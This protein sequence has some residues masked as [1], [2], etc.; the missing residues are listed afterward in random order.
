[1]YKD[2]AQVLNNLHRISQY[3]FGSDGVA[4]SN[5]DS[6]LGKIL[7]D[8][9]GNPDNN[10]R[11]GRRRVVGTDQFAER[12][13]LADTLYE[14]GVRGIE[15]IRNAF[16][17]AGEKLSKFDAFRLNNLFNKSDN[18]KV[19]YFEAKP[20]RFVPMSEA[21][22]VSV[23]ESFPVEVLQQMVEDGLDVVVRKNNEELVNGID[24]LKLTN[25]FVEHVSDNIKTQ[26]SD[27][28]TTKIS[29]IAGQLSQKFISPEG[30]AQGPEA[31]TTEY[32]VVGNGVEMTANAVENWNSV[33]TN[34][35]TNYT[36][37]TTYNT[38]GTPPVG[39][40]QGAN[41]A[42]QA[43]N[44]VTQITGKVFADGSSGVSKTETALVGELGPEMLV[45]NGRWTT[46]GDNGAEFTQV[47]K[48]DIIF[49][50]KQTEE[51]LSK[52]HITGRGKLNGGAFASGTA[53]SQ[54]IDTWDDGMGIAKDYGNQGSGNKGGSGGGS[55]STD[56]LNEVF[57]WI[58]VRLEELEEKLS[59]FQASIENATTVVD[60]NNIIDKMIDVNNVKLENLKAGYEEYSKYAD[61]LLTEVPEKYRDAAQNGAIAIEKF[62][63]EADKTTLEAIQNYREWVQKAADLKQQMEEVVAA[64]RDLAIE[65][66]DN[67]Q[68]Y[69]DI[70]TTVEDSQNEKLQN[71]IDLI[72]A[73]GKIPG[74]AYYGT[75]AG[76]ALGSTGMFENSYKKI[77]YLGEALE[78]MQAELNKA[79]ENGELVRGTV[80]WYEQIDKLYQVQSEIAGATKELEEFQNAINDLHWENFDQLINRLDYIESETQSLVDLMANDDLV[81]D[82]AK[83]KY[84]NGTVE[85][86]T[87]EDVK[88]TKEGIA[89]LGL[90]AQ[91]M[92]LAEFRSKQYAEAIDDLTADYNKRLYSENEYLEKLNE[93]KEA[94]YESI[95]AYYDAQ[96]A[97]KELNE[98]RI[99]SIKE[100]IEK[101]IEAYEELIEAKKE[102]LSSEK[103]LYDF[104]KQTMEQE[105]NIADI[106]RKLA[107]LAYDTS[108]SAAAQRKRLE[109]ELAEAN[110]ELQESYYNRSIE[111]QQNALDQ[112]LEDFNEAKDAEIAKWEEYAEDIK[113]VITDSLALVQANATGIY[114]TLSGKAEEYN[115]TL[116][117]SITTP[118]QDGALAVDEYQET[119]GNAMSST[120]D[121][122][123][124]MKQKWQE[125]IAEMERAS[126]AEL[127]V[128]NKQNADYA[129]ATKK[130]PVKPAAPSTST[131]QN[132]TQQ[133]Q[134]APKPSLVKGSY[135]E[136]KPGTRWYANSAGGGPSGNAKS[137]TIK[138]V[139]NSGAYAYNIDGLGW[140]K[141]SDIIGY[142][143]GTTGVKNDQL[144][145]IDEMGLEELVMHAG[146]DGRL[147]YL[148]KGS[149]VIPHDI[150]KNL[151]EIGQLDPSMMIDQNRPAIGASHVVN[152][153]ISITMDIAEVVHI[154][155]VTNDTIPDLTKAV[156]KQ[157]DSYMSKLN[158][159]IKSKVR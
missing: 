38:T 130:E 92:E 114:D 42:A 70:R 82:P 98:A 115:L 56:E 20:G 27:N 87:A 10:M 116:S 104:Q 118:W 19:N 21:L 94:Q 66:I 50:H 127:D 106:E 5:F 102:A 159:A 71:A 146:P 61:S 120:M 46:I 91:Q 51:L 137:G 30:E 55:D 15:S 150:T 108:L 57:D 22:E 59:L 90:Y 4:S 14:E 78:T 152:N 153:E 83:S 128:I 35:T 60:K 53:Y 111:D 122:L 157:M 141:K 117:D 11:I 34:K 145:W 63:G 140:I 99:D 123:E 138:Y 73:M 131:N 12:I 133:P 93:L 101:E 142:K 134:E 89:S 1:V 62:V 2:L 52:G 132:T 45:R 119:F 158:N 155:K 126:K 37:N 41:A 24:W 154:D 72:E 31:K 54:V 124:A 29:Q 85:Y 36:V 64:I 144:A 139:N 58:E 48:G 49:N 17:D 28:L 77:E 40:T 33:P 68:S 151:M 18:R 76:Q 13:R 75:N 32:N 80:E 112:E 67:A 149:A 16:I 25:S 44:V 7:Y 100:G 81:G 95:E 8:G 6:K 121:Q 113:Q 84:E 105:K 129:A 69:G 136:V 9:N 79:V 23:P 148:S 74:T 156:Q 103:D 97:I 96:D 47:K 125:V 109:A 86:W 39:I 65:R 3:A 110:A 43:A 143:S 135:V 26:S 88:Y 147:Q 107:A